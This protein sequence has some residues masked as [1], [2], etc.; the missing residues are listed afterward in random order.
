MKVSRRRG[1]LGALAA[2]VVVGILVSAMAAAKPASSVAGSS[3]LLG[4]E[5]P[6]IAGRGL[7]GGRVSL[8]S[9]R[10]KWVLVNFMATWC[11]A[12]RQEMPQLLRFESQHVSRQ[13]ATVLTVAYDPS[14]VGQLE[15][16][17]VANKARW[18]AV[19]DPSAPV[20]YGLTDL[21]SSFLVA[22]DGIVYAYVSGKVTSS[23]LDSWIHR[24][25]AG[26]LGAS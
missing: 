24:G 12:C 21:P 17:L 13:D 26:G 11:V 4:K 16:Y 14:N 22:P 7:A 8:A 5:A 15:S 10:G 25:A 9:L 19:D 20:N 23:Q 3:P 2:V 6:A 1:A 18:P